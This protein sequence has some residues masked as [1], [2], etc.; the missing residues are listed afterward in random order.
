MAYGYKFNASQTEP[1]VL[2][3]GAG[4]VLRY[5]EQQLLGAYTNNLTSPTT[6]DIN[7]I[8]GQVVGS[9]REVVIVCQ[10][11][12]AFSTIDGG[13]TWRTETTG[14]TT[15]L[16]NV[17]WSPTYSAYY[18]CGA[19][20]K[21]IR[22]SFNTTT[23]TLVNTSAPAVDINAIYDFG[24]TL[25]AGASGTSTSLIKSTN[26]TSWASAGTLSTSDGAMVTNIAWSG[27]LYMAA[28]DTGVYSNTTLSGT[29]TLRLSA[30]AP[31]SV[32]YSATLA[33][34][35]TYTW[36]SVNNQAHMMSTTDGINY[37]N[38]AS[39]INTRAIAGEVRFSF[40]DEYG[41]P[42]FLTD[43]GYAIHATAP[44]A[45]SRF[46]NTPEGI[47][48]ANTGNGR[49]CGAGIARLGTRVRNVSVDSDSVV[50]GLWCARKVV[51]SIE[52]NI[53]GMATN[54]TTVVTSTEVGKHIYTSDSDLVHWNAGGVGLSNVTGSTTGIVWVSAI[55]KYVAVGSGGKTHTSTDGINWVNNTVV[56]GSPNFSCVATNGS[57]I[58]A[59]AGVGGLYTSTDGATWTA[60]TFGVSSDIRTMSYV[61]GKFFATTLSSPYT[62]R[63]SSDGINWSGATISPAV[64]QAIN[65]VTWDGTNYIASSN[66][67]STGNLLYSTNGTSWTSAA[68]DTVFGSRTI[69]GMTYAPTLGIFV[70]ACRLGGLFKSQTGLPGSWSEIVT[71]TQPLYALA[72]ALWT[73]SK[74]IAYGGKGV[75]LTS[76][77]GVNWLRQSTSVIDFTNIFFPLSIQVLSG[78][79]SML[80]TS[81]NPVKYRFVQDT[82]TGSG[83]LSVYN[84][85]ETYTVEIL[86]MAV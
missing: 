78:S 41:W 43:T 46:L 37:T 51:T 38:I 15:A 1:V 54:G 25:V 86:M 59:G 39:N 10:N 35:F 58:V 17:I 30:S 2:S 62:I 11:G 19:G 27:A 28:T 16:Y 70:A 47:T 68:L 84:I 18:A 82:T 31:L 50:P 20:G 6:S 14:L 56:S 74:L 4:G 52:G 49:H 80:P 3:I 67:G 29:W 8:V 7:S 22:R 64:S 24:G 77:D 75:V 23:W 72:G 71:D 63:Y 33:K 69:L 66:G 57:L 12:S 44:L 45:L 42:Y 73:G 81:G 5:A 21:I 79:M 34:F 9:T 32:H 85:P 36:V 26:G 53:S 65:N 76:S 48:S 60:R 13:V 61:N 40:E 55:S 83:Y